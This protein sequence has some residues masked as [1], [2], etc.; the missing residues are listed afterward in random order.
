MN[1]GSILEIGT[2]KDLQT[3]QYS[4]KYLLSIRWVN[5]QLMVFSNASSNALF[6]NEPEI[7]NLLENYRLTT[8]EKAQNSHLFLEGTEIKL[9]QPEDK[10][11][12]QAGKLLIERGRAFDG[13][14]E[15]ICAQIRLIFKL[16]SMLINIIDPKLHVCCNSPRGW[17]G[18]GCIVKIWNERI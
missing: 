15:E 10:Y 2:V 1:S 11:I 12:C 13:L 5:S 9:Y 3:F 17:T 7:E 14:I 8:I 6:L 18:L 16:N 4:G